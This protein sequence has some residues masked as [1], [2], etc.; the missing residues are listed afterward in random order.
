[1]STTTRDS[2]KNKNIYGKW[3][4]ESM[5]CALKAIR[6]DAI[7]LNAASRRYNIPKATLK[8][9]LDGKNQHAVEDSKQFGRPT[10]LSKELEDELTEHI[11]NMEAKV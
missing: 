4:S 8:R 10:D 6:Q 5:S 1:M 7:G 9:H 2:R 11:M 3:T